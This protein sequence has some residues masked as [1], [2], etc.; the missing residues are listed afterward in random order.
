MKN[1]KTANINYP[2]KGNADSF[3]LEQDSFWFNHR[4]NV[5]LKIIKRFPF[6]GNFVDIG[7]GNGYQ[8]Q[9]LAGHLPDKKFILVEPG[10]TGCQNA[11]IRGIKHVF[12]MKFQDL[13]FTKKNIGGVGLFDVLEHIKNDTALL[14]QLFKKCKSGTLIYITVPAYSWLWSD[15]DVYGG[16][17]RRYDKSRFNKIAADLD[18]DMIYFSYYFIYLPWFI[19]ITRSLPDKFFPG[20][21]NRQLMVREIKHHHP[22]Y[23]MSII[24]KL[25]N[26]CEL[27]I[28]NKTKLYFGSSCIAVFKLN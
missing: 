22:N 23:L 5:I 16:H 27:F 18:I 25:L 7:G 13:I 24:I 28:L 9:F 8:V 20:K 26:I 6:Y 1:F 19:F 3:R 4:N 14:H 11:R 10:K 15:L 21:N 2:Q 17:F 12:N